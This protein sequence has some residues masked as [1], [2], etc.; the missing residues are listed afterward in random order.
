MRSFFLSV[1]VSFCEQD[2]WKSNEPISL[3]LGCYDWANQPDKLI[4]FWWGSGHRYGF[5]IT[6]PFSSPLQNGIS[7]NLLAFLIQSLLTFTKLGE[8]IDADKAM[9]PQQF[10]R[11]SADIQIWIWINPAIRIEIPDHFWLKFWHWLRFMFS[12]H[13]FVIYAGKEILTI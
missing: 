11:D 3:K 8:M 10:V 2:Y 12:E 5:H 7:G 4:N 1:C 6:F 9:N 13:S